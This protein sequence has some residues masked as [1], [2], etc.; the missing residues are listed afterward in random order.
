MADKN[1]DQRKAIAN[2][3]VSQPDPALNK[4]PSMPQTVSKEDITNRVLA[5]KPVVKQGTQDGHAV[6]NHTNHTTVVPQTKSIDNAEAML[7]QQI[8]AGKVKDLTATKEAIAK[9]TGVWPNGATN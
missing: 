4:R 1:I 7:R 2:K 8:A 3:I 9:K 5:P 6:T